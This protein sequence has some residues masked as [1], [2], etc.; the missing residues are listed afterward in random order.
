MQL[1]ALQGMPETAGLKAA[2][3]A[4]TLPFEDLIIQPGLTWETY[5]RSAVRL[6]LS[7]RAR[8]M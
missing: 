7:T 8:L 2:C 6:K 5:I 1:P 4:L 3:P